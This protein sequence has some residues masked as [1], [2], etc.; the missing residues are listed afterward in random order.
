MEAK[1]FVKVYEK[2]R[3]LKVNKEIL[4]EL[5]GG[6]GSKMISKMKKEAVDCPVLLREVAFLECFTCSNFIRRIRGE[7]HCKGLPLNP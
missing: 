6:L 2:E 5:K 4:E 1:Y 7:V 3:A